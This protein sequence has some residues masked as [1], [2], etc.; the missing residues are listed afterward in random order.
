MQHA[1]PEL[2]NNLCSTLNKYLPYADDGSYPAILY[3]KGQC[4]SK[5]ALTA[6]FLNSIDPL[7]AG[8]RTVGLLDDGYLEQIH[9][10]DTP[11]QQ[12]YISHYGS[13]NF[14]E[15]VAK[16]LNT[17]KEEAVLTDALI[18]PIVGR[19]ES[20]N[21]LLPLLQKAREVSPRIVI[22][23]EGFGEDVLNKVIITRIQGTI[24]PI[25]VETPG[26]GDNKIESL[27][28]IAIICGTEV[29]DTKVTKLSDVTTFG[30]AKKVIAKKDKTTIIGGGGSKENINTRVKQLTQA[31]LP[32]VSSA[33]IN[34]PV[35]SVTFSS[36]YS[37]PFSFN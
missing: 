31:I 5:F 25:L 2:Y 24:S 4:W 10:F 27:K 1:N 11:A 34:T 13:P 23:A 12:E 8:W 37:S 30:T 7:I 9:G 21:E 29:I 36:K 20:F 6:E 14:R 26:Y 33:A 16:T 28:D 22:V 3:P 32:A 19:L 18:I 17:D 35:G 15:F